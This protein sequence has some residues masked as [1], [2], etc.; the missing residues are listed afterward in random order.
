M[1][2]LF[3]HPMPSTFITANK[4]LFIEKIVE[5][6]GIIDPRELYIKITLNGVSSSAQYGQLI[7]NAPELNEGENIVTLETH[8]LADCTDLALASEAIEIK[9]HNLAPDVNLDIK[10]NDKNIYLPVSFVGIAGL[11]LKCTVNSKEY[12]V[13][14]S[15]ATEDLADG[16]YPATFYLLDECG[17]ESSENT[18]NIKVDTAASA[19][20]AVTGS[21]NSQST[22][23]SF[24]WMNTISERADIS[25]YRYNITG[26]DDFK[27]VSVDI[28]SVTKDVKVNGTYTIEVQSCD[29]SG[30]NWSEVATF[31][32]I[33]SSLSITSLKFI[34]VSD[35][36]LKIV[37]E[38][39]N[40]TSSYDTSYIKDRLPLFY[41]QNT[42]EDNILAPSVIESSEV[43]ENLIEQQKNYIDSITDVTKI[44]SATKV[45]MQLKILLQAYG[46]NPFG[47]CINTTD[48]KT[49][50]SSPIKEVDLVF[51]DMLL[52][53]KRFRALFDYSSES[54]ASSSYFVAMNELCKIYGFLYF[55]IDKSLDAAMEQSA[56]HKMST[57]DIVQTRYLPTEL[58]NYVPDFNLNKVCGIANCQF[59]VTVSDFYNVEEDVLFLASKSGMVLETID[60][61]KFDFDARDVVFPNVAYEF[62]LSYNNKQKNSTMVDL[63]MGIKP[64][65][66]MKGVGIKNED[67]SEDFRSVNMTSLVD[68]DGYL[69]KLIFKNEHKVNLK[70]AHIVIGVERINEV[71]YSA[72]KKMED[73]NAIKPSNG[74][75]I[76]LNLSE[77]VSANL[78]NVAKSVSVSGEFVKKDVN[79]KE[80]EVFSVK[81]R[82]VFATRYSDIEII[83]EINY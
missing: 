52:S 40:L 72:L 21:I 47:L 16:E 70:E 67:I 59:R 18:I 6:E 62:Y 78:N 82:A 8:E 26:E 11:T 48:L 17:Y 33:V 75:T 49:V 56:L 19:K 3:K 76:N 4:R 65:K 30:L 58:S 28:T 34:N 44:E 64:L 77:V 73:N 53:E 54:S 81:S 42:D 27:E 41:L 69:S 36:K 57:S 32:T 9:C 2:L 15:L 68:Q 38:F 63:D 51:Q 24:A 74:L 71:I 1:G 35:Q 60:D 12:N 79:G 29:A 7:L 25:K 66:Y 45:I 14:T 37:N 83:N 50:L 13:L 22:V 20:P 5:R 55:G 39:K 61:V 46:S 10:T 43:A 23:I 80:L 31:T